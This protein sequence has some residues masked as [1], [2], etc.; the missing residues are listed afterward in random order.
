[1]AEISMYDPSMLIWQDET[2]CDGHNTTRKY[3]HSLRG[4]PLSD[5]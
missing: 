2:G 3:G 5:H 1:M 4:M